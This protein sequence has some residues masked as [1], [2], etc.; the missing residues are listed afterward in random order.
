VSD[1][2]NLEERVIHCSCGHDSFGIGM[3]NGMDGKTFT[4]RLTCSKCKRVAIHR[5]GVK[6]LDGPEEK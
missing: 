6:A 2:F 4:L 1:T 5:K 3:S